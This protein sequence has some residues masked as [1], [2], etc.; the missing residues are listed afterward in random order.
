MRN[1]SAHLQ[2]KEKLLPEANSQ[3]T[4]NFESMSL[5]YILLGL[6]NLTHTHTLSSLNL[7]RV[8]ATL[9]TI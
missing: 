2:R 7:F 3:I 1:H 8:P 9:G 5:A 6:M 4:V